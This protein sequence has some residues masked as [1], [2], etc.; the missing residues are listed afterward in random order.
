MVDERESPRSV[1]DLL[2]DALEA[3]DIAAESEVMEALFAARGS[4]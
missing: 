2:R 1:E 4:L 3:E